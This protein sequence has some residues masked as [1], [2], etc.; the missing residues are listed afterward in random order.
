MKILS[1]IKN[2]WNIFT[3]E[4]GNVRNDWIYWILRRLLSMLTSVVDLIHVFHLFLVWIFINSLYPDLSS[5]CFLCH[6]FSLFFNEM[7]FQ[8]DL[9]LGKAYSD[10]GH[11]SDAVSVYDQL[12]S[13]H[14]DDFRGYLAKVR[15]P[16]I[17]KNWVL[18]T[19]EFFWL[20]ITDEHNYVLPINTDVSWKMSQRK[21]LQIL[22]GFFIFLEWRWPIIAYEFCFSD[23][24][25][26]NY[27]KRKRKCWRCRE[28]VY[29]GEHMSIWPS[30]CIA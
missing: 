15:F 7:H 10:W 13:S 3:C 11:V 17:P 16:S 4:T 24:S 12:I 18:N 30:N 22:F 28:D 19:W 8:V 6:I 1:N 21:Q 29:P 2:S 25:A 26:G 20:F 14:P 23:L 5:G 9:L 27:I